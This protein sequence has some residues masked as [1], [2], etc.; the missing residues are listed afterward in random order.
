MQ[1]I[2]TALEKLGI[3]GEYSGR[4]DLTFQGKKISGNAFYFG[5]HSAYHHGTLLV[6]TDFSKLVRYLRV[7]ADKIQSKGIDS[8]RSRVIN[9]S[10]IREGLLPEDLITS[11]KESFRSIYGDALIDLPFGMY[12]DQ[13]TRL[14]QKYASW[15]WRF[16]ESP[17]FDISIQ[18][19]FRWGNADLG[20]VIKNG[21]IV[22]AAFYS[23]AMDSALIQEIAMKLKDVPFHKKSVAAS[24]NQLAAGPDNK[25][26]IEDLIDWLNIKI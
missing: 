16:G 15:H 5:D 17:N 23:D 8:V 3:K 7:S 21:I 13:L 26:I 1:V 22:S 4:N 11:L 10:D 25:V 12:S 24:L 20:F 9:L 2:L 14:Y 19:R 18:N 6:N